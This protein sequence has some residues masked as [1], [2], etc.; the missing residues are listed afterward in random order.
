MSVTS[1]E[2]FFDHT[3]WTKYK[4]QLF[5]YL[6]LLWEYN[7]N[8][9]LVSRRLSKEQ[10]LEDHFYDS[11]IAEPYIPHGV[12]V[13]DIGSGAGFPGLCWALVRFDLH[14]TLIEKSF[15]K[16]EFLRYAAKN[17]GLESR[18]SVEHVDVAQIVFDKKIT[19]ITSRAVCQSA[20]LIKLIGLEQ[21]HGRHLVMMKAQLDKIYNE[22]KDLPKSCVSDIIA[23]KPLSE[24]KQ[25][26][27][28][29]LTVK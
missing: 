26:N 20:K 18:V 28:M 13:A 5:D 10:L 27:L 24:K 25:R 8:Y 3:P 19:W 22:E 16:V 7:K 9:N 6:D 12:Q 17:L 23:L 21:L 15:R 4:S 1:L 29:I 2:N 11:L 14:I